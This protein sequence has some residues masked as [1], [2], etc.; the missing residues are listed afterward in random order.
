MTLDA[1]TWCLI[2][3]AEVCAT[4]CSGLPKASSQASGAA[5]PAT[6]V[7]EVATGVAPDSS[8]G[9]SQATAT[10][11]GTATT[12]SG[13]ATTTATGVASA[14]ASGLV[15]PVWYV[16]GCL[17]SGTAP[18]GGIGDS[19]STNAPSATLYQFAADGTGQVA[20]TQ[21]LSAP[22]VPLTY[23]VSGDDLTVRANGNTATMTFQISKPLPP[24]TGNT[25]YLQPAAATGSSG[26]A[27]SPLLP[28][29]RLSSYESLDAVHAFINVDA[30]CS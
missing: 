6:T 2:V 3:V 20:F 16:G 29:D 22:L 10:T 27:E 8:T 19:G 4:G 9:T 12:T 18:G 25:L 24:E 23:T 11:S 17:G 15:G 26:A 14:A 28:E 7:T 30:P 5:A 1:R 21:D 13:T